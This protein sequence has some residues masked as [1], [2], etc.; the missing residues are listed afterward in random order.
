[1]KALSIFSLFIIISISLTAQSSVKQLDKQIESSLKHK[2]NKFHIRI[3][4]QELLTAYVF[5]SN[6]QIYS[7]T[8]TAGFKSNGHYD[9]SVSYQFAYVNDT[10]LRVWYQKTYPEGK[11]TG[12]TIIAYFANDKIIAFQKHGHEDL[13]DLPYLKNKS[14]ELQSLVRKYFSF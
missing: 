2:L 3:N 9:S 11:N 1:M 7:V 4:G 6:K 12:T 13:P 10:L 8:K 14:E 5:K